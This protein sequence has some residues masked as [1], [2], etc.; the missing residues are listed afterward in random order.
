MALAAAFEK[1]SRNGGGEGLAG[2]LTRR[3]EA[4]ALFAAGGF[5]T[6]RD[7]EWRFTPVISTG[8]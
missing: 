3:R 2:L 7:E 1:F 4:W 8:Y 6:A 5:P